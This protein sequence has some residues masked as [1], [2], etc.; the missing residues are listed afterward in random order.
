MINSTLISAPFGP[1]TTPS[2]GLTI[3]KGVAEK[4]GY[5]TK[6]E[7]SNIRF[8]SIIGDELYNKISLG[9]PS[10]T[11]LSGEYIFSSLFN[12][13]NDENI[14]DYIEKHIKSE[15]K[16]NIL[17][18]DKDNFINDYK[19]IFIKVRKWVAS[20]ANYLSDLKSDVY[21][22]TSVFQQNFASL[23]LAREIKK[24]RPKTFII[25]GGAN[26]ERP[27]GN[28][29]LKTFPFIDAICTGEGEK[30]FI[31]LLRYISRG[32]KGLLHKNIITENTIKNLHSLD[33]Q[34]LQEM[35]DLPIVNYDDY[36]KELESLPNSKKIQPRV[37]LETSRGC[38]WGEKSHC[39]FCGLN[40]STMSFRSKSPNRALLEI[41]EITKKYPSSPISVVDNIID[42]KYFNTL[43]PMLSKE[44]LNVEL[45]YETKANIK[46]PQLIMMRKAGITRIQ[47]GIESL[48]SNV[49]KLMKKGVKSIQ[50]ICLLKWC[51][52]E[53][54][55]AEWNLLWGFP[56]E[57][58]KDY[59][60][61]AGLITKLFHLQPPV[62]GSQIRLDRYSPLYEDRNQHDISNVKPYS[63]Y[64]SIY[65][66]SENVLNNLAYYFEFNYKDEENKS[67]Y[68]K[69]FKEK[70]K[71][72]KETYNDSYLI[73][74]KRSQYV[75]IFDGRLK[76]TKNI[77]LSKE[78]MSILTIL[79][80]PTKL[81]KFDKLISNKHQRKILD[82]LIENN[83]VI[84]E[85][86]FY[87][88]IAI[89]LSRAQ[90]NYF[91][92]NAFVKEFSANN[93]MSKIHTYFP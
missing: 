34:D 62:S 80:K 88:N 19:N 90:N 68:I 71:S 59:Q 72:W 85:D 35:D 73:Y 82:F 48:S 77:R 64:N 56:N 5:K 54:V 27:M 22:F 74:F 13:D 41:K 24:L 66:L 61:M 81:E 32:R 18:D 29:L 57:D 20:E 75:F 87:F 26:C 36:F 21:G 17:I 12:E 47:P 1:F 55:K 10:N 39:T 76:K 63:A 78:A 43:L 23:L 25:L 50:N 79:E 11:A 15:N 91:G 38:W 14:E 46:K 52:E 45:F 86:G 31:S 67:D 51:I 58:P 7:Y 92:F 9:Y 28:T 49:L 16:N 6:I 2:L 60:K 65:R 44:K 89:E 8:A 84:K 3:L 4:E 53:G 33:P 83:I 37:L 70:V 69:P 40:A 42:Y 30:A 93:N